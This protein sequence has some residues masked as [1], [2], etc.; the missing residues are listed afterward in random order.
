M[1]IPMEVTE[2]RLILNASVLIPRLGFRPLKFIV[3]TGSPKTFIGTTDS[4]KLGIEK[5]V[6]E[7]PEV[8]RIV[9]GKTVMNLG[10]EDF[11]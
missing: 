2:S 9:M 10:I 5:Y 8:E 4:I 3:D 6:R 11:E 1:P 7:S